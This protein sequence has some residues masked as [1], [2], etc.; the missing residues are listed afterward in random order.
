MSANEVPNQWA[1]QEVGASLAEKLK[2]PD[3]AELHSRQSRTSPNLGYGS[4]SEDEE[5]DFGKSGTRLSTVS[6][7][8]DDGQVGIGL[9]LMGALAGSDSDSED[10]VDVLGRRKGTVRAGISF[11]SDE[12]EDTIESGTQA[13][14]TST[15]TD[16]TQRASEA[17]KTQDSPPSMLDGKDGKVTQA[18]SVA[19]PPRSDSLRFRRNESLSIKN[20]NS[21]IYTSSAQLSRESSSLS[22]TDQSSDHNRSPHP[23]DGDLSPHSFD[24]DDWEGASDIYDNYRYS[25][26]SRYSRL[27]VANSNRFSGVSIISTKVSF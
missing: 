1:R 6:Y 3:V 26:H 7:A 20:P 15:H 16:H 14:S 21:S 17:S 18:A 22:P 12:D 8:S 11:E 13:G 23:S 5:F 25:R 24:G 27:S 9:S 19:V 4:S 10:D 2:E